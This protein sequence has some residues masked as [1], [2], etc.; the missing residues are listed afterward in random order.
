MFCVILAFLVGCS[1]QHL[2]QTPRI[3][4]DAW[5]A[6]VDEILCVADPM[7]H[8]PDPGSGEWLRAVHRGL[9]SESRTTDLSAIGTDSWLRRVDETVFWLRRRPRTPDWEYRRHL[10]DVSLSL[11]VWA[12][13]GTTPQGRWF[14]LGV[15]P[16]NGEP[17]VIERPYDGTI[18]NQWVTDLDADGLPEMLLSV[19]SFG[20]GAYGTVIVHEWDGKRLLQA[21]DYAWKMPV[22]GY[23]GHDEIDVTDK[24]ILR[25]FPIYRQGDSNSG[26]TGGTRTQRYTLHNGSI[27]P[28]D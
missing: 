10:A 27:W 6:A 26:P 22:D 18:V 17:V 12:P 7:G 15:T 5:Y 9:P 16:R 1:M 8:G 13:A 14:R 24:H 2:P 21:G 20:S 19:T 4:S 28:A 23:M 25:A 11:E 3:G